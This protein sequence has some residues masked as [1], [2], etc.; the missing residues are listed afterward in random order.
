MAAPAQP[1]PPFDAIDFATDPDYL[2]WRARVE[3]SST[4]VDERKL[5]HKW[6]KKT[7]DPSHEA[8]PA[9]DGARQRR[10]AAAAAATAAA[11]AAAAAAASAPPAPRQR[12]P[13]TAPARP[14]GSTP[15]A[16]FL[17][18]RNAARLAVQ[19]LLPLALVLTPAI[20]RL[21]GFAGRAL[22][23]RPSS[24]VA[25][26]AALLHDAGAWAYSG[27]LAAAFAD[28]LLA[29]RDKHGAPPVRGGMPALRAWAARA[30]DAGVASQAALAAW[31]LLFFLHRSAARVG[32]ALVP[33]A[34]AAAAGD[35]G[36]GGAGGGGAGGRILDWWSSA[37]PLGPRLATPT[38][39][40]AA[41][42]VATA[43]YVTFARLPLALVAGPP[44][45]AR[46]TGLLAYYV[47]NLLRAR[48]GGGD[49]DAAAMND[50]WRA[51]G[52]WA[53]PRL[54]RLGGGGGGG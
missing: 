47:W 13:P 2:A 38:Q 36:G 39:L 15:T 52:A 29:V 25:A 11:A 27:A 18:A 8:P 33:L 23:G 41:A 22:V 54:E 42:H 6:Y 9:S 35:G 45:S 12:P 37:R 4:E 43:L 48:K 30:L 19:A 14:T 28:R 16:T 17:T 5:H 1:P 53:R 10:P 21:V 7:H 20:A 24:S 50:A 40:A 51:A 26:A 31:A 49:A 3:T 44:G 34:V 46:A 32:L